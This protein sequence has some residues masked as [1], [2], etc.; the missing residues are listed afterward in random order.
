MSSKPNRADAAS[1]SADA[2]GTAAPEP[3]GADP[4]YSNFVIKS[5]SGSCYYT[6]TGL[7]VGCSPVFRDLV[8]CCDGKG[9]SDDGA[10][11]YSAASGT[12]DRKVM[13]MQIQ[14]PEEEIEA[15]V[16]H[17]HQPER[18]WSS[19]VPSVTKEG[20]KRILRLTPIASK[21]DMEGANLRI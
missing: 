20:A 7:V 18:F 17:L 14:N 21:Y 1:G 5:P 13:E 19:V 8:E 3:V 15:L 12:S 4:R 11:I 16:E 6:L 2:P 10:E 9:T